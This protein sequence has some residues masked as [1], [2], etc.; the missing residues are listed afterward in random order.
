[1]M[2]SVST[3]ANLSSKSQLEIAS[4]DQQMN[5]RTGESRHAHNSDNRSPIPS[6]NSQPAPQILQLR[7]GVHLQD[8][9]E[10]DVDALLPQPRREPH[11]A[12]PV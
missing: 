11:D 12:V 5:P 8:V 7:V 9:A 3:L 10:V 2:H 1:V 6:G 4:I